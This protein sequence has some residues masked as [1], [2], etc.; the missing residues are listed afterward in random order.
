MNARALHVSEDASV[1]TEHDNTPGRRRLADV[2]VARAVVK[3][4]NT[5]RVSTWRAVA[6]RRVSRRISSWRLV[7]TPTR[8]RA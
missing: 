1:R 7:G 3:D 4:L 5:Q 8:R 2:T 6:S